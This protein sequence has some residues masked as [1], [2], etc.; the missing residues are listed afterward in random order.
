MPYF[1]WCHRES[2]QGHKDFQTF[3]HCCNWLIVNNLYVF[4]FKLANILQTSCKHL[5]NILFFY[6]SLNT[7]SSPSSV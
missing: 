2:N 5:A 4:Y 1:L 7:N 3:V 6:L